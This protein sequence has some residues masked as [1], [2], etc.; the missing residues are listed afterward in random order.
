MKLQDDIL[1]R[2]GVD[3]ALHFLA[4][5][6]IVALASVAGLLFFRGTGLIVGALT[7]ILVTFILSYY[8]EKRMDERYDVLDIKAAMLG[9]GLTF[10]LVMLMFFLYAVINGL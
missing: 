8:K 10:I 6:L 2:Y 4:G 3:K 5:A 9:A 1:A 7:A